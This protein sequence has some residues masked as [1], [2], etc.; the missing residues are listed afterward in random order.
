M[1]A[2]K[3]T[4]VILFIGALLGVAFSGV[5]ASFVE[6]TNTTEFCIS[7][8]EMRDT[9]YEEYKKTSHYSNK[10]G[11]RASC[12]DCHV[13]HGSW[14][15]MLARKIRA[16]K[17]LFYHGTGILDTAEEL[18]EKRL[19]LAQNVWA[20]MQASDSRECRNCHSREAMMIDDQKKRAQVQHQEAKAEGK[21][22]IDCHKGI[23]HKDVHTELEE[24]EGESEGFT[25]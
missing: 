25:L 10:Y 2:A 6:Y 5:F 15:A 13:P 3:R 18:E 21:T 9:V 11:V 7:C 19:E 14:T 16:T 8:H 20:G 4:I 1:K 23:A 12:S 17:E 24:K 22:C